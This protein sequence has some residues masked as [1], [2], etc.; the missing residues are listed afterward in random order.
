L[1]GRYVVSK[2]INARAMSTAIIT[3]SYLGTMRGG[4]ARP[5]S[6]AATSSTIGYR[7]HS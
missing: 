5:N 2:S 6:P 3:A 4:Q 7:S 1:F